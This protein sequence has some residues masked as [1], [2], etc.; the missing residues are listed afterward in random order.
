M[1][2]SSI[3]IYYFQ[4]Y[5]DTECMNVR[6]GTFGEI[7]FSSKI[8]CFLISYTNEEKNIYVTIARSSYPVG[9]GCRM[10]V[11]KRDSCCF[12]EKYNFFFHSSASTQLNFLHTVS[13]FLSLQ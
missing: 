6:C 13:L 11:Q 8:I 12:E 5:I 7:I 9:R 3:S 10:K 1:S 2:T 4:L